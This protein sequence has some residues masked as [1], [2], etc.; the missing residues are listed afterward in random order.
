M[1]I[2]GHYHCIYNY[3]DLLTA[4]NHIRKV[5]GNA[6]QIFVGKNTST[7]TS[8]KQKAVLTDKET[9]N[10][11]KILKELDMKLFIH[12]SLSLNLC[13]PLIP[14]YLW[15]LENLLYDLNFGHKIGAEDVVIHLGTVMKDRYNIENN[16][17]AER[18]AYKNMVK[19]LEYVAVRVP[20]RIKILIETSAGQGGKI[21]TKVEDL[22]KL[23]S[24]IK[25][26]Y[27]RKINF[28][29]DTCHIFS[30]GYPINHKNGWKEYIDLFNEYIGVKYIKLIHLNDSKVGLGEGKDLHTNLMKGYIFTRNKE[31]LKTIVL[32]AKKHKVPMILETR[33]LFLYD[34][35]IKLVKS[36][37]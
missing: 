13:N 24:K 27:R 5:G 21:A 16:K 26:I 33:D 31:A 7:T 15:S 2:G 10:I 18:E 4:I 1:Y 8:S 19:S 17:R 37:C 25:P 9:K 20:P 28:C 14:K 35:E 3:D 23:Y 34:K 11:K 22:G 6:L 36:L 32:W 30:A 29:V 12:G